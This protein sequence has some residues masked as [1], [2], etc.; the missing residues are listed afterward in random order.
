MGEFEENVKR[1]YDICQRQCARNC[2]IP[3]ARS[4][5]EKGLKEVIEAG[6]GFGRER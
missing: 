2:D 1:V 3:G 6:K 5:G 4:F